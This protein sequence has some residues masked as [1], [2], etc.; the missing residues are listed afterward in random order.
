[1]LPATTCWEVPGSA[2][3]LLTPAAIHPSEGRKGTGLSRGP[4][5]EGAKL[6]CRKIYTRAGPL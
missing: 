1:M 2:A 4:H 3:D 6:A 5:S